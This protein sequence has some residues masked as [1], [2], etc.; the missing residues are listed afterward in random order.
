[1]ADST[2]FTDLH[3]TMRALLGDRQVHEVWNYSPDTLNSALRSVF[4]TGRQP[5]GYTLVGGWTGVAIAPELQMGDHAALILYDACLGLMVGEDGAFS[6]TTR[7]LSVNDRGQRKSELL[8]EI[9]SR[10]DEIRN[11]G[12]VWATVQNLMQFIGALP[13][14]REGGILGSRLGLAGIEVTAADDVVI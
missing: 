8:W 14:D 3:D 11:G 12:A 1:M 7:S 5:A 13:H 6:Y 9:R 10:I 2:P 4:I